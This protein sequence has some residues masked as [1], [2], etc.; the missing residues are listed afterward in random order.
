MPENSDHSGHKNANLQDGPSSNDVRAQLERVLD[1]S[2]FEGSARRRAL[3]RYLVEQTL[4]GHSEKLKG[5]SIALDVFD[6]D[7]SFDPA[8]DP[9][10]RLEAGRLRRSLDTFYVNCGNQ[11]TVRI[12]IPKGAYVA[13]FAW[14][15][16]PSMQVSTPDPDA[17]TPQAPDDGKTGG[18]GRKFK[19]A[20]LVTCVLLGLAG[21]L[22]WFAFPDG[23]SSPKDV[24]GATVIVLPF[25]A[26]DP[27]GETHLF[28]ASF[29]QDLI[30]DL[31]QF[32]DLR[33]FSAS[34]SFQQAADADPVAL[35]RELGVSYV[36]H[37]N[38][39]TDLDKLLLKAQLA[40]GTTGEVYWTGRFERPLA[41]SDLY[42]LRSELSSAVA[43][44]LGERNG[45]LNVTTLDRLTTDR[46]FGM[47]N[48]KCVLRA[49]AYRR[50][51][52][53]ALFAPAL[54]CL[55]AARLRA[56]NDAEVWAMLGYL[57][58]DAARQGVAP[59][60][61]HPAYMAEAQRAATRAL[62]LEPNNQ[63][64]LEALAAITYYTGDFDTAEQMQ[65][66]VVTANPH[67]PE[68]MALL[69][70]RLAARGNWEDGLPY[71]RR[72][73]ARS[74]HPPGWYFHLIAIHEYLEG[75]YADAL[76]SAE[77]SAKLGSAI[78]LSLAAI[79][80]AKLGEM[81]TAHEELAKMAQA[82]PLLARDP[83]ATFRNFRV[84]EETIA[85]LMNGL[86][87]AGWEP[88]DETAE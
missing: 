46:T 40:D 51:F 18:L 15:S 11:D 27:S 7:E 31:M 23:E 82:W 59:A 78:G 35:G 65:R 29:A 42:G 43:T 33:L 70:W 53:E 25:A 67:D 12:N 83:A 73:I 2:V 21:A 36:V 20:V 64:G 48:Y 60:S 61:E 66:R 74:A 58:L 79:N 50:T 62:Q 10:V 72:A 13:E 69:G 44:A 39:Q 76:T 81:N 14:L 77:H 6:R 54:D 19:T 5:Y 49:Y 41:P 3:L 87:D 17:V 57:N 86:R 56:P 16:G 4:L 68:A 9:V 26:L 84:V 80:H 28:A 85:A 24:R 47:E 22:F 63:H 34:T 32:P 52:E 71:L 1:S 55:K 75:N 30:A 8:S 45:V 37:G 38:I 88:P